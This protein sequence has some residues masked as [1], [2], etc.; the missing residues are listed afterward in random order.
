[1]DRFES[2]HQE[3]LVAFLL[4]ST[5]TTVIRKNPENF[6]QLIYSQ[7]L[8]ELISNRDSLFYLRHPTRYPG[9]RCAPLPIHSG[10]L[11][12]LR[13]PAR[14]LR[15]R[16]A[17]LRIYASTHPPSHPSTLTPSHPHTHPLV[18]QTPPL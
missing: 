8:Q 17:P 7:S 14:D 18:Q 6:T 12:H 5:G 16:R 15:A 10:S 9:V 13:H 2:R 4:F 11:P 1:M 3:T